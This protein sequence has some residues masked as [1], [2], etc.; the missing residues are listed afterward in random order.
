METISCE[1][2]GKT[3]LSGAEVRDALK[4]VMCKNGERVVTRKSPIGP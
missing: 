4:C 1:F 3:Y 2:E